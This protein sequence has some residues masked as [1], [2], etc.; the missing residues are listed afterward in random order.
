MCYRSFSLKRGPLNP[1]R[2]D[3]CVELLRRIIIPRNIFG[4]RSYILRNNQK[5]NEGVNPCVEYRLTD[6]PREGIWKPAFAAPMSHSR[7]AI[8]RTD[9]STRGHEP[10]PAT[11]R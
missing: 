4:R 9:L 2:Y 5:I 6:N 10:P 3:Y 1:C 8:D 7:L 11:E